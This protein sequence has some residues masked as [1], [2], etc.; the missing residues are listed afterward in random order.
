MVQKCSK[1]HHHTCNTGDFAGGWT[2]NATM[3]K[4]V[5]VPVVDR[6]KLLEG[7]PL[8]MDDPMRVGS[9]NNMP[10]V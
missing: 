6:V 8:T 7:Y 4:R 9:V 5:Q 1:F 3:L 2:L 10:R